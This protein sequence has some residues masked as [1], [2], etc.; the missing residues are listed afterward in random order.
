MG[1]RHCERGFERGIQSVQRVHV[2]R[3][4]FNTHMAMN[5][6]VVNTGT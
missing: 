5:M 1:G 2:P 4:A 3:R 6:K